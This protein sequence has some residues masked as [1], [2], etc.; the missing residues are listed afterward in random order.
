MFPSLLSMSTQ[1]SLPGD[2]FTRSE[3]SATDLTLQVCDLLLTVRNRP[4]ISDSTL[5]WI[6]LRQCR[7]ST[8]ASQQIHAS[9]RSLSIHTSSA[10]PSLRSSDAHYYRVTP[11]FHTLDLN[12]SMNSLGPKFYSQ[13]IRLL[14]FGVSLV[15]G[16][17]V[18]SP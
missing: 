18:N 7:T 15:T 6:S 17:D 9:F 3:D 2:S 12:P 5:S 10:Q 1:L 16:Y 14:D 11:Y 13:S 4:T 8:V